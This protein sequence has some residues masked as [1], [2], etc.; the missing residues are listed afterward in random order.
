MKTME[1]SH[2]ESSGIISIIL[3]LGGIFCMAASNAQPSEIRAWITFGLGAIASLVS[4][5]GNWEKF[6][7]YIKKTF[8][9]KHKKNK[10]GKSE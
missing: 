9:K 2:S 3:W 7:A 1:H 5:I 6:S 8:S 4:I 10:H